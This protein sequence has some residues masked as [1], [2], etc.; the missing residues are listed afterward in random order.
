MLKQPIVLESKI[1]IRNAVETDCDDIMRLI[2]EL[3]IFEKSPEQVRINSET[4]KRD[5]FGEHPLYSCLVA[6]DPRCSPSRVVGMCLMFNVYSTWEGKSLHLEDL[7]VEI[8]YRQ[9]GIGKAFFSTTYQI[10]IDTNCA[11]LNFNVLD[12]NTV[13]LDFYKSKGAID[14]TEKEGWHALRVTRDEM[15]TQLNKNK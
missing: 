12:W 1:I 4:L 9:R 14:F 7:Y 15:I 13:A 10:A 3:A 8:D 6:E 5:G 11:R 2:N